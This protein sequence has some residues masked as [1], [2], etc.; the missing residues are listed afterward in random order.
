M[1]CCGRSHTRITLHSCCFPENLPV[2][3]RK[4]WSSQGHPKDRRTLPSRRWPQWAAGSDALSWPMA[5]LGNAGSGRALPAPFFPTFQPSKA[6]RASCDVGKTP[7]RRA[8]PGICAAS[9]M[10]AASGLEAGARNGDLEES[11]AC[12]GSL[13]EEMAPGWILKQMQRVSEVGKRSERAPAPPHPTD[14]REGLMEQRKK[15]ICSARV[16]P[17]LF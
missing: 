7:S 17:G 5:G 8:T 13:T 11:A 10:H 12:E 15:G 3:H 14:S 6:I 16:A 1:G 4:A 2:W 9:F